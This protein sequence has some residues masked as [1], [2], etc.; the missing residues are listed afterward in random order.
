MEIL[1]LDEKVA[2]AMVTV[3]GEKIFKYRNDDLM[4]VNKGETIVTL[5]DNVI[6]KCHGFDG[7]VRVDL[8]AKMFILERDNYWRIIME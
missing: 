5:N 1:G 7:S 8:G 4:R 3:F 2:E 6:L